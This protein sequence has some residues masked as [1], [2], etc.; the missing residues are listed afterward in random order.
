MSL[1]TAA[2]T[3]FLVLDP[4]GNI[5]IFLSVLGDL[6]AQRR[7]KII[8]RETVIA[9]LILAVF[10]FFGKYILKG[11][12]I[13]PPAVS[14]GGGTVLFLIALRMIFPGSKWESG[15][16]RME[17]D[18]EPLIVP[19]AVPLLAGPSAMAT[20]VLFANQEPDRLW[21][22]FLALVIAWLAASIVLLGADFLR[23]RLGRRALAALERLMG[24]ILITMATEMLLTGIRS[25]LGEVVALA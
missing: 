11:M 5:P 6:D 3:L 18:E 15:S 24:M 7:R 22:W 14:I 19:L 2:I 9:L 13:S 12:N 17:G 10:L 23:K 4:I 20:L 16:Q 21:S 25:F 1:Y 8:V